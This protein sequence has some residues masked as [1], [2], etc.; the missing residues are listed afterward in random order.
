MCCDQCTTRSLRASFIIALARYRPSFT[1]SPRR[2]PIGGLQRPAVR[3]AGARATEQRPVHRAGRR[4]SAHNNVPT[5]RLFNRHEESG[6]KRCSKFELDCET[7]SSPSI[8]NASSICPPRFFMLIS[9]SPTPLSPTWP[10]TIRRLWWSRS[11]RVPLLPWNGKSTG[12]LHRPAKPL[13]GLE[14]TP[15][16]FL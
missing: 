5:G 12:P 7:N 2:A 6:E 9:T 11:R 13:T 15:F 4:Q 14:I 1:S 3:R 16:L 10:Q 8:I